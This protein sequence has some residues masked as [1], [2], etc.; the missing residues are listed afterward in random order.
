MHTR[1]VLTHGAVGIPVVIP[2]CILAGMF[3]VRS[4][5][6]QN[7]SHPHLM[8]SREEFGKKFIRYV[9]WNTVFHAGYAHRSEDRVSGSAGLGWCVVVSMNRRTYG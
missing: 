3:L 4:T 1:R 8:T 2:R 9:L 7:H 5:H 6:T